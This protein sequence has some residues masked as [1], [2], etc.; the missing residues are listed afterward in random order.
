MPLGQPPAHRPALEQE[1]SEGEGEREGERDR[2]V[3]NSIAAWKQEQ[4]SLLSTV[5]F[6]SCSL[7]TTHWYTN[8][9]SNTSHHKHVS[10]SIAEAI[11]AQQTS[12]TTREGHRPA[13]CLGPWNTRHR[14]MQ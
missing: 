2:S 4:K 5:L 3:G 13:H 14:L 8:Q 7:H 6:M 1:G 10:Q 12:R 9:E 11:I